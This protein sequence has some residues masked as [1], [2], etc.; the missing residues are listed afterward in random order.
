MLQF[1]SYIVSSL[2]VNCRKFR[3][4]RST[5][6]ADLKLY[7]INCMEKLYCEKTKITDVQRLGFNRR[8]L[9][10]FPSNYPVSSTYNPVFESVTFLRQSSNVLLLGSFC[11]TK[12]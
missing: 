6:T 11:F 8:N 5:S 12:L 9:Y 7:P 3:A 2:D 1:Q 10:Y 4:H